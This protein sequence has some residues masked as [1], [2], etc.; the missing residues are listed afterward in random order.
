MQIGAAFVFSE[1]EHDQGKYNIKAAN[2]AYSDTA[3]ADR[4]CQVLQVKNDLETEVST[5]DGAFNKGDILTKQYEWNGN[6]YVKQERS[7]KFALNWS[8][9][10]DL[11]PVGPIDLRWDRERGVWVSPPA[12]KIVLARLEESIPAGGSG[13]AELLNKGSGGVKFYQN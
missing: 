3:Y 8:E 7:T 1:E 2:D 11:W 10:P 13:Q 6:K 9:K 12:N 4:Q 5:G